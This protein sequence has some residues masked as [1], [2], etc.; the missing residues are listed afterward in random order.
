MTEIELLKAI[1]HKLVKI[2]SQMMKQ[3]DL[4]ELMEQ[5]V[6]QEE[7]AE[8]IQEALLELKK[9]VNLKHI[10]NINSDELILR[11][12]MQTSGF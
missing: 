8:S 5:F 1:I 9:S 4:I 12:I 10:E 3:Q 11:S 7:Y 6:T 2:E